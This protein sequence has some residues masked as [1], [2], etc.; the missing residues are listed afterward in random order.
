[1]FEQQIYAFYVSIFGSRARMMKEF[2][3][4][5]NANTDSDEKTHVDYFMRLAK[6]MQFV[7]V[8]GC[9]EML[10]D[11]H[12]GV[13][14]YARSE[15]RHDH[16]NGYERQKILLPSLGSIAILRPLVRNF[17]NELTRILPHKT[18]PEAFQDFV[19]DVLLSG[20]SAEKTRQLL[21]R[22][23]NT[24][25]STTAILSYLDRFETE[26]VAWTQRTLEDVYPHIFIDGKWLKIRENGEERNNVAITVLGMREDLTYE[27]LAFRLCDSETHNEAFALLEDV[28]SR[29][30]KHVKSVT[31]DMGGGFESAAKAAWNTAEHLPCAVH[32][33]RNLGE[34]IDNKKR[35]RFMLADAKKIFGATQNDKRAYLVETFKAKW[36]HKEPKAV[37]NF[38]KGLHKYFRYLSVTKDE[39]TRKRIRTTNP[40]ERFFREVERKVKQIGYFSSPRRAR[41]WFYLIVRNVSKASP[42]IF[43]WGCS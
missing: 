2:Y 6:E 35:S 17:S 10:C 19:T 34:N 4:M 23:F 39:K 37:R 40:I 42:E 13:G 26:Y 32:K 20:V 12:V 9:Y 27:V 22:H 30:V 7:F 41:L 11:T 1:M 16:R 21:L 15:K 33:M 28:R 5:Y 31:S 36:E 38:V 43:H 3:D 24:N 29:G 18:L 25:V 14:R 8:Q